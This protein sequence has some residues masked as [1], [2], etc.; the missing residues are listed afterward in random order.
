MVWILWALYQGTDQTLLKII[1]YLVITFS[2][3]V[4]RSILQIVPK[5]ETGTPSERVRHSPNPWSTS[6]SSGPLPLSGVENERYGAELQWRRNPVY[7]SMPGHFFPS[8]ISFPGRPADFRGSDSVA[9]SRFL[10]GLGRLQQGNLMTLQWRWNEGEGR[11]RFLR[12]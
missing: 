3:I 10:P 5:R 4:K 2:P 7:W 8:R 6:S 1:W 9:S 12:A 11:V